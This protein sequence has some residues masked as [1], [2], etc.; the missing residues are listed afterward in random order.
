MLFFK[1]WNSNLIDTLFF[2]HLLNIV[3]SY[4]KK[5][6]IILMENGT[7]PDVHATLNINQRR[8]WSKY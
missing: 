7:G 2:V 4:I 3:G 8:N 5:S 6:F 1:Q